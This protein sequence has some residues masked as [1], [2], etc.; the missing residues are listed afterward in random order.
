MNYVTAAIVEKKI[1]HTENILEL[2]V[3]PKTIVKFSPGSFV[4]LTLDQV[5]ASQRWPESRT[6]SIASFNSDSF[7]FIIQKQ[8]EYTKRIF[9]ETEIGTEI[10]IKYPFGEMFNKKSI[11]DTHVFIA[12][13]LGIT[14]FIGLTEYFLSINKNQNLHLFYSAKNL[15]NMIYKDFFVNSIEDTNLFIT[16]EFSEYP[17]RRMSIEDVVNKN[18]NKDSHFYLCGSKDFINKFKYGL[19]LNDFSNIHLDEWE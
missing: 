6:F 19:E 2:L 3:R 10:T 12:G 1:F 14:P 18:F 13:G 7:R 16:R 15:E 9:K 11:D 4:Q 17:Y 8:G 5:T